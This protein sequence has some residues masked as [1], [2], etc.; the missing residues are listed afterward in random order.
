MFI[1]HQPFRTLE[2]TIKLTSLVVEIM[3]SEVETLQYD[4]K[5]RFSK[6]SSKIF[7]FVY[8]RNKGKIG[9]TKPIQKFRFA[10]VHS[11]CFHDPTDSIVTFRMTSHS[12]FLSGK[13]LKFKIRAIRDR[14][15]NVKI[16]LFLYQ[17]STLGNPRISFET[18]NI[19]QNSRIMLKR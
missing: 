11:N 9:S 2:F 10:L 8:Q 1:V 7:D 6:F 16:L 17:R 4:K 3:C 18:I 15:E 19:Q 14:K 12:C 13:I 5:R